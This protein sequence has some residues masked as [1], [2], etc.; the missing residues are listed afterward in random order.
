MAI[1]GLKNKGGFPNLQD[2]GELFGLWGFKFSRG[3]CISK[4]EKPFLASKRRKVPIF[5]KFRLQREILRYFD[6]LLA[7]NQLQQAI[8]P[9]S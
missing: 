1:L 3:V 4:K 9:F 5:T 8:N 7:K 2:S 6:S